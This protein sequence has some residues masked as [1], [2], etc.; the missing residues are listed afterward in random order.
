VALVVLAVLAAANALMP[1]AESVAR[2]RPP[3]IPDEEYPA[4][5]RGKLYTAEMNY[6]L[7]VRQIWMAVLLA[8][9]AVALFVPTVGKRLGRDVVALY[10]GLIVL[11][12]L[13]LLERNYILF[14]PLAE[15]I[16]APDE[17][18]TALKADT[19][20]YRVMPIANPFPDIGGA[21]HSDNYLMAHR[22]RTAIGYNGFEIHAYDELLGG[23]NSWGR[24]PWES[25]TMHPRLWQLLGVKYVVMSAPF[26]PADTLASYG[27]TDLAPL[28]REFEN[29]VE[30][31][32]SDLRTH[33]G[34]RATLFRVKN[35]LPFA[36]L[37]PQAW[38]VDG[39]IGQIAATVISPQ[40]DAR[41]LLIIPKDSP[42]GLDSVASM[43]EPIRNPVTA[44]E[45]K[46]GALRFVLEQ[47][48]EQD[49]YLFVAE[50]YYPGWTATVDGADAPVVKAQ[51]SLMAVPVKA[52]ARA[53]ELN[54]SLTS[55][56]LGKLITLSTLVVI[57]G[58]AAFAYWGS[59]RVKR[60][61]V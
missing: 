12:D 5:L 38:R 45:P 39:E 1:I 46:V 54:F 14:S 24:F 25:A 4:F 36:Y 16:F 6:A 21:P 53:V 50:N 57:F 48:A 60:S 58:I 37:V 31:V 7:F 47:P 59:H 41:G 19:T 51:G 3:G 10:L 13:W 27:W 42:F 17:V 44:T 11:T 22:I 26:P 2:I 40:F 61:A 55:F 8:A 56:K 30:A 52:G 49:A 35:A 43:G 18:V 15:A 34:G 20:L 32:G 28:F 9:G 29:S 33:D 23:K